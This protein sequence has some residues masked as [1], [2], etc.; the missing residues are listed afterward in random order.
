VEQY[1]SDHTEAQFS[2]AICPVCF[3]KVMKELKS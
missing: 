3:E 1:V 2:H